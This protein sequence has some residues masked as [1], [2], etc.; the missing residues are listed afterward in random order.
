MTI[1][2][3]EV[4]LI[5]SRLNNPI[6][7][8]AIERHEYHGVAW[9]DAINQAVVELAKQNEYFLDQLITKGSELKGPRR[10]PPNTQPAS[11]LPRKL[12]APQTPPAGEESGAPSASSTERP[13]VAY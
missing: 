9:E 11:G 7:L 12:S 10:S 4:R 13:R 2:R 3:K 8:L 1:T 6:L 5:A